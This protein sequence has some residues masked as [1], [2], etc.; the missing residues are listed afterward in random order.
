MNFQRQN[1][2]LAQNKL[3]MYEN[4]RVQESANA[5]L[6]YQGQKLYGGI[7]RNREIR[8]E[9]EQS[10]NSIRLIQ[11]SIMKRKL[12][13]G[14]LIALFLLVLLI[15]LIMKARRVTNGAS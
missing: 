3:T 14:S 10:E 7:E 1:A 5:E 11:L 12:M 8:G 6:Y 2:E 13:F 9:A 4:Q 15:V